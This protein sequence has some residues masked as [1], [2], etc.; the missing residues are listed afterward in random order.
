MA[1]SSFVAEVA[2]KYVPKNKYNKLRH[3]RKN[4]IKEEI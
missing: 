1:K 2:F 4:E 3:M